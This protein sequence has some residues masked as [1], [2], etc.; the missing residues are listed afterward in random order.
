MPTPKIEIRNL[1]KSFHGREVVCGIDLAIHK[2]EVVAIIGQS[3]S[4]KS[5]LLRTLNRLEAP[6]SG[7]V[8]VD[9]IEITADRNQLRQ[10]RRRVGM[11]FQ[12]FNLFPHM[13]AL[14]N[15]ME[16]PRTVLGHGRA[17]AE[18]TARALL[19]KVGLAARAGQYP[20]T[21][22]GGEQQRVS[23]ARALAMKP[24]VMLF[25]E[26]TSALDPE[27]VGDVLNV[28]KE[29]ADEGM[30]MVAV[31]HEMGF[32]EKVATRVI[33][34]DGG[35]IVEEGPPQHIFHAARQERTRRF[36][37]QLHWE[38]Q[39]PSEADARASGA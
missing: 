38:L 12:S 2:G 31:T 24:E 9:G 18:A 36:L 4:G 30:T 28:M 37:N 19:E 29:L 22:S 14:E 21:L 15:V 17:E 26:V 33:F 8:L 11:V 23:I 1:R 5:T 7:Q 10:M 13:T 35:Q 34:M 27:R 32:A 16:G 3:G 39:G 20:A 6:T 25:D